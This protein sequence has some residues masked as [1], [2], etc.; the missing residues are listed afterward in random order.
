MKHHSVRL[1]VTVTPTCSPNRFN[2][3]VTCIVGRVKLGRGPG[4]VTREKNTYKSFL[5]L[6]R[7]IVS[8]IFTEYTLSAIFW[9]LKNSNNERRWKSEKPRTVSKF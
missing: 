1:N 5:R 7:Y 3:T 6:F 4:W 9:K 2:V 8:L